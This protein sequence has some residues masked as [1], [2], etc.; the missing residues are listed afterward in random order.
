MVVDDVEPSFF[1]QKSLI[2]LT[3]LTKRW[4]LF[5]YSILVV[6]FTKWLT[7]IF[8]F[9]VKC[10]EYMLLRCHDENLLFCKPFLAIIVILLNWMEVWENTTNVDIIYKYKKY[11]S[12]LLEASCEISTL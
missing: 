7:N 11:K 5:G 12:I 8:C 3:S 4:F 1:K 9:K 2:L 6:D 10:N